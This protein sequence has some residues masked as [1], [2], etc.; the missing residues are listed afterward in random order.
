MTT[1]EHRVGVVFSIFQSLRRLR[2]LFF[3]VSSP[4]TLKHQMSLFFPRESLRTH[5][6]FTPLLYSLTP[7]SR[8]KSARVLLSCSFRR[9]PLKKKTPGKNH[10]ALQRVLVGDI[11][12]VD[13]A[14]HAGFE[15]CE[16]NRISEFFHFSNSLFFVSALFVTRDI[17]FFDRS[18]DRSI[19]PWRRRNAGDER[20]TALLEKERERERRESE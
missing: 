11:H 3:F 12:R 15:R 10:G 18:I 2:R 9:F 7:T 14:L 5:F 17:F 20:K 16:R 8:R 6:L 13:S 4:E 1:K 19:A